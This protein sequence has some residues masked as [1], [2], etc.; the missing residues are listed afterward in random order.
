[1]NSVA[2]SGYVVYVPLVCY[3]IVGKM[4]DGVRLFVI[5]FVVGAMF[6]FEDLSELSLG[7]QS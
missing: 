5:D 2:L 7:F 4:S 6:D 3:N 1:V